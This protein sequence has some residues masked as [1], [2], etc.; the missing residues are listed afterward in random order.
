MQVVSFMTGKS[1]VKLLFY[2][3][4]DGQRCRDTQHDCHRHADCHHRHAQVKAVRW[5]D[6]RTNRCEGE[7]H[8]TRQEEAAACVV[9]IGVNPKKGMS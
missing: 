3:Q 7:P 8:P 2:H 9:S 5:N 4:H 1:V 6:R